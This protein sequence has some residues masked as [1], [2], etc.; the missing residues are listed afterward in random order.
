M[1]MVCMLCGPGI[2]FAGLYFVLS[3]V[4]F[5]IGIILTGIRLKNWTGTLCSTNYDIYDAEKEISFASNAAKMSNLW[6]ASIAMIA[7][8]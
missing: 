5:L 7:P 4:L 6:I 3:G 2:P 1:G 8:L